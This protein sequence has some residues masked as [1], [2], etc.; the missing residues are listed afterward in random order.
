LTRDVALKILP[1]DLALDAERLARFD[2]EAQ[3]LA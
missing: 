3:A 1:S 2:R